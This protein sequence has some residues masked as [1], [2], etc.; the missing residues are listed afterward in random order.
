MSE[1]LQESVNDWVI[2]L[3]ESNKNPYDVLGIPKNSS[4]ED[5]K[6][7][8]RK[9]SMKYHPDRNPGNKASEEMFKEIS[10][11]YEMI[12]SP[13]KNNRF[14]SDEP[15]SNYNKPPNSYARPQETEAQKAG[16]KARAAADYERAK[17]TDARNAE[18]I[19]NS[20]KRAEEAEKRWEEFEAKQKKADEEFKKRHEEIMNNH[21][22]QVHAMETSNLKTSIRSNWPELKDWSQ[23]FNDNICYFTDKDE[24]C[25]ISIHVEKGKGTSTSFS[26]KIYHIK[27][28]SKDKTLDRDVELSGYS[29]FV[30]AFYKLK[31]DYKDKLKEEQ[32]IKNSPPTK[33]SQPVQ[34]EEKKSWFKRMFA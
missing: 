21:H 9:L 24:T 2:A 20:Q 12:K 30:N 34:G 11:A 3:L 16:R 22:E 17:A 23:D 27:V 7:A 19:K 28:I 31:K 1:P 8:Y 14:V 5:A 33:D 4:I 32:R 26:L 29:A 6:S 10:A 13:G 15:K 25:T 18:N